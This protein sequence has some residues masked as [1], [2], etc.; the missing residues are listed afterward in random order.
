M[1]TSFAIPFGI[2]RKTQFGVS[3]ILQCTGTIN[4]ISHPWHCANLCIFTVC[5][6]KE[7]T[8]LIAPTRRGGGYIQ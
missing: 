5:A 1:A 6:L 2:F 3:S 7:I 4:K 8:S